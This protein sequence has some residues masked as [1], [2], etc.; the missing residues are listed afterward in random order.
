MFDIRIN[1]SKWTGD[2]YNFIDLQALYGKSG[3]HIYIWKRA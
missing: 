1:Y 2:G 3:M